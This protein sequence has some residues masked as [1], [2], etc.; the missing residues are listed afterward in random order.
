MALSNTFGDTAGNIVS[1]IISKSM[2]V[3]LVLLI[4][5]A[6]LGVALYV[7]WRRKFNIIV[8]IYS[9]R[10]IGS[11]EDKDYTTNSEAIRDIINQGNHKIIFDRGAIVY[12]KKDGYWYF[13]ILGEKV[14]LPEPPFNVLQSSNKGNVLKVWQKS[15]DEFIFLMP[16]KLCKTH[17][18]K[19]GGKLYPISQIEQ[20][21][22]E[23]DI[24][25]WNV[26]RKQKTKALFDTESL[27]M[28]ILP[29]MPHIIG[30]MISLF[31]IYVLMDSMP[32]ILN[33]LQQLIIELQSLK[34][35]VV[36]TG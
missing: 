18:I 25:Y 34:G 26:K 12:D 16:D 27:F 10:S 1:S 22:V 23:G 6:I 15:H 3:L 7:R 13:R 5:G 35:A 33:Q 19:R 17:V 30:G 28:K 20:K 31:I 21:Q 2:L 32:A 29:F 36:T 8:E 9:E 11:L 14:D 24:G 4:G